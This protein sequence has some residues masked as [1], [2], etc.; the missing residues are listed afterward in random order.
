MPVAV[1]PSMVIRGLLIEEDELGALLVELILAELLQAG[2][3]DDE[4]VVN[5]LDDN[6]LDIAL[7]L[8][9][10]LHLLE[11]YGGAVEDVAL[12]RY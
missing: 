6:H 10:N 12:G 3:V 9:A 1:G 8:L 7:T 5:A 2:T 4:L 11:D